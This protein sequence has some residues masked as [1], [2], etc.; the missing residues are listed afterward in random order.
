MSSSSDRLALFHSMPPDLWMY[1]YMYDL[2]RGRQF[3]KADKLEGLF[4]KLKNGTA[5]V[6]FYDYQKNFMYMCFINGKNF[7]KIKFF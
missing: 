4:T 6:L 1:E 3:D 5:F 2:R 7:K